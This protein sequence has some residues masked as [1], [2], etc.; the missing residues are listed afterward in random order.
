MTGNL[1][2]RAFVALVAACTIAAPACTGGHRSG[3]GNRN[4]GPPASGG[5][6]SLA[7]FSSGPNYIFPLYNAANFTQANIADLQVLLYRP[8]Y[9]FG[10]DDSARLNDKLSLADSPVYSAGNKVVTIKLKPY[11]WSDGTTVSAR[12]VQFWQNL[13]TANK[14]NWGAYTPGDYPDNIVSTKVIDQS[15]IQFVL[16]RPYDSTWFT[17]NELSQITPLPQ[18]L[19]DK[20]SATS[21]VGN[22]DQSPATA[23]QVYRFLDSQSRDLQRY[24]TN[25]LW[26]VV[27]GPWKISAYTPATGAASF[28]AN[29]RYSGPQKPYLSQ[30]DEQ[31]FP[32]TAAE[33]N[34][35][36][37]GAGPQVGY[38]SPVEQPEQPRLAAA[39]Y[40]AA[41]AYS[42]SL[43][44][45]ALNFNNPTVG[46]LFKQAYIRQALQMLVDQQGLVKA[47]FSNDG[48]PNCGP[49]PSQPA[50]P[51][52]DSYDGSCPYG[53]NPNQAI[54]LLKSR[55]WTV[56][57][58]GVSTCTS[59]GR[60]SNQCG[61]GI[62]QGQGLQFSYVYQAGSTAFQRSMDQQR[63]DAELAGVRL[64]L[65]PETGSTTS[66]A[67]GQCAPGPTCSWEIAYAGWPFTPD[68]YPTGEAIFRTGAE[69][70]LGSYSDPKTDSLI[71]ATMSP[72]NSQQTLD[73]YQDYLTQQVPALW[74]PSTFSIEEV[75]NRLQGVTPFNVF[76]YITPENWY[77]TK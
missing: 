46:P 66:Q 44:Y 57:P 18:H 69:F 54:S 29:T 32:T 67:P 55:G 28:V 25:P 71:N 61:A 14:S 62:R 65:Q 48:Y 13:V 50:N 77:Y 52:A 11:V 59:P 53:Y 72:G 9:W 26:S 43:A 58:G 6:A 10:V 22:Y 27:D 47:Y 42:F 20:I 68:F 73:S 1:R 16:N 60:A 4:S 33:F 8:L 51:F 35:L 76:G 30:F 49:V 36:I 15:T 12:D 34:D 31:V 40:S 70:N 75:S 56:A 24:A 63:A 7:L 37:S 19:W 41:D 64:N 17:Y 39:G 45:S 38:I 23:V 5:T 74:Q 3:P 21:P 2:R